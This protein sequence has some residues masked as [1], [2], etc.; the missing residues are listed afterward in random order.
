[1]PVPAN[2][3]STLEVIR[4]HV[5]TGLPHLSGAAASE[6]IRVAEILVKEFEPI[7]LYVFGSHAR[8]T[9]NGHSDIDLFVEVGTLSAM[10]HQLAQR[11]FAL[12]GRHDVPLDLVFMSTEDVAWRLDVPGSLP[13]TVIREGHPIYD[14]TAA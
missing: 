3:S 1:M 9:G 10:P 6:L 5:R 11:A 2:D 13:A 7:R 14:A 12:I 8:G 4:E